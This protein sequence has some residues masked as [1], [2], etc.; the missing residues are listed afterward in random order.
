MDLPRRRWRAATA[1]CLTA[2]VVSS[3]GSGSPV[4]TTP[5]ALP[6][7]PPASVPSDPTS[8]QAGPQDVDSRACAG[9]EAILAHITVDTSAW[10]PTVRPF[11]RSI[12]SR[13]A[14]ETSYLNRQT[15][16]AD[17]RVRAAVA[18]AATAFGG[19]SDAIMAKS[20]ARLQ[21]AIAQSRTAYAVLK[22]VCKIHA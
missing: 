19:V 22:T 18:A 8:S 13:L 1:A 5:R 12:A 14:L 16:A 21:H 6:S 17:R 15:V 2:L 7:A 9:V 3:C 11:D 10:S 20:R 4:N